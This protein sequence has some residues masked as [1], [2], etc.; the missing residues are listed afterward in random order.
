M[1]CSAIS[2]LNGW[3]CNFRQVDVYNGCC[4]ESGYLS[5]KSFQEVLLPD[6]QDHPPHLNL[7]PVAGV[8]LKYV[9]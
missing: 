3:A 4:K 8:K 7:A 1:G 2:L 6:N 9:P 5:L